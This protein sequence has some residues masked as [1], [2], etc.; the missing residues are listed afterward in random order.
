MRT[1]SLIIFL[2]VL[3]AAVAP[4]VSAQSGGEGIHISNVNVTPE[5]PQVGE[6]VEMTVTVKNGGEAPFDLSQVKLVQWDE[7]ETIEATNLGTVSSGNKIQVPLTAT[8]DSAGAKEFQVRASGTTGGRV[9]NVRYPL[10]VDVESSRVN[11]E[12][13]ADTAAVGAWNP[14]EVEVSN[15]GPS[16]VRGLRATAEGYGF[17][18]Q[19]EGFIPILEPGETGSMEVLVS[20]EDTGEEDVTVEVS[21]TNGGSSLTAEDT[22]TVLFSEKSHKLALRA[23]SSENGIEAT[24]ANT[25]NAAVQDVRVRGASLASSVEI[26]GVDARS[27]ET[28]EVNVTG[29]RSQRTL[30]LTAT[31]YLGG[32]KMT[33]TATVEY[34]PR[35]N[36][37]LTG[38]SVQGAGTVTITGSTSNVGVEDAEGVIVE[39]ADA[40]NVE[41]APPQ[42]DYFVGTVPAS[43]FGTFELNARISGNTSEIP[44][45]VSYVSDGKSYDRVENVTY[46][47]LSGPSSS[48]SSAAAT[49][50][51]GGTDASPGFPTWILVVLAALVV[52]VIA[53]GWRKKE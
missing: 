10:S 25:G 29:V 26:D 40:E 45:K 27:S 4:T 13:S 6:T 18:M 12:A 15:G 36:I 30:E 42:S 48:P 51:S 53:Y 9:S 17:K 20:S 39:V 16:E 11:V 34:A 43:D 1:A 46:S 14:I 31:Y 3:T 32:E 47:G 44:I 38:T 2:V 49:P 5:T 33:E 24:V 52:G 22:E 19:E 37:R 35:S 7:P 21:Y 50:T 41:P 23:E 28:V 8:F